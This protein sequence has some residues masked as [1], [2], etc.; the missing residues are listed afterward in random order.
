MEGAKSGTG[1]GTPY[2]N[3]NPYHPAAFVNDGLARIGE[4]Q[5]QGPISLPPDHNFRFDARCNINLSASKRNDEPLLLDRSYWHR[6]LYGLY[7]IQ[8]SL[9]RPLIGSFQICWKCRLPYVFGGQLWLSGILWHPHFQTV[10]RLGGNE[11]V[12]LLFRRT[13]VGNDILCLG[14]VCQWLL[15]L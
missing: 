7:T 12:Y 11:L 2:P 3:R 9:I 6:Y 10:W 13:D 5:L 8:L 1:S 14:H 15:L 4:E